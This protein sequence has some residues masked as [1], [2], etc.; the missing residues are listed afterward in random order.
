MEFRHQPEQQR[1]VAVTEQGEA[2][3][4][5]ATP[6]DDVLDLHHTFVP[7]AAR[8]QGVAGKLVDY[9][10]RYAREHGKKVKATCPYVRKWM[11]AH[12]AQQDLLV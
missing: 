11:D 2:E 6:S 4:A 5:Y 7:D 3:I 8:G 10:V 1:F 9:A 12:P